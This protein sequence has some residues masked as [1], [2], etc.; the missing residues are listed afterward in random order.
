MPWALVRELIGPGIYWGMSRE[1]LESAIARAR[2]MGREDAAEH[3]AII[4]DLRNQVAFDD[5]PSAA[6]C[7]S[8]ACPSD[9]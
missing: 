7:P 2:G 9:E 1:H 6:S 5:P 4:L 3:I 8:D